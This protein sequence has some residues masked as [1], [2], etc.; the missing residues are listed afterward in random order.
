MEKILLL[1]GLI[2]MIVFLY[3]YKTEL[4]SSYIPMVFSNLIIV[5]INYPLIGTANFISKTFVLFI[6][7]TSVVH[8]YLRYYHYEHYYIYIKYRFIHFLLSISFCITI[9]FILLTSPQSIY[10]SSAYLS[11]SV[12][13]FGLILYQLSEVD[14]PVRWFQIDMM[15]TYRYI[16]HPKQFG[17]I[18]FTVSF[19]LLTMFLPYSFIYIIIGL[20]YIFYLIRSLLFKET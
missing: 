5:L 6:T 3:F 14:R 18:L 4:K 9:P 12:F 10:Q 15:N 20:C 7:V 16:K 1:N 17:E 13:I 19:M 2:T 11:V 8:I